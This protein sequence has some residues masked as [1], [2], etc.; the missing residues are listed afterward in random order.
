MKLFFF[1]T[2]FLIQI[3][4]L[5]QEWQWAY[6]INGSSINNSIDVEIDTAGNIWHI[7]RFHSTIDADPGPFTHYLTSIDPDSYI[8]KLDTNMN[9]IWS[10]NITGIDNDLYTD[11]YVHDNGDMFLTGSFRNN[12]DLDPGPGSLIFNSLDE[13]DGFLVKMDLSGNVV[14]AKIIEGYGEQRA[15]SLT[16]NSVG[17][18][19]LLGLFAD[20]ADFDPGPGIF[21]MNSTNAGT[22]DIFLEKLDASGNF[23]WAKSFGGTWSAGATQVIVDNNDNIIITGSVS[24]QTDL[25]P[26][27]GI[28]FYSSADAND[29][30]VSKFDSAGN[31]LWGH[32]TGGSSVDYGEGIAI[33]SENNI[34]CAVRYQ[35]QFDAK[36]GP[37]SLMIIN[38]GSMDGLILKLNENG[39]FIWVYEIAGSG[40][41]SCEKIIIDG[42][43]QIFV[44]GEYGD[45]VDFDPTLVENW[46]S[47][48]LGFQD[49]FVLK[50][51]TS[52]NLCWVNTYGS[53]SQDYSWGFDVTNDGFIA[54][55]GHLSASCDF[56]TG[57]G[58]YILTNS[59]VYQNSFLTT[60]RDLNYCNINNGITF[61]NNTLTAEET[62]ATYQWINCT[63]E[64]L[65][66]GETSK[67][68]VVT[69]PGI[70][71]AIIYKGCCIDTTACVS[72]CPTSSGIDYQ[73]ACKTYSWLDG[74]TYTSSNNTAIFNLVGGAMNGC[75]SIIYL[76]LTINNVSDLNTS[77][78]GMSIT[79]NNNFATSF[80]W[81]DCDN[82]FAQIIGEQNQTFIATS[83]GNYAVEITENECIDTSACVSLQ[84]TG[85]IQNEFGQQFQVYPNPTR[86]TFS[87]ELGDFPSKYDAIVTD[88][89]GNIIL[90]KVIK[91]SKTE[92]VDLNVSPGEYILIIKSKE[93]QAIVR[94]LVTG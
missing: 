94:L 27:A 85:I 71:A 81:L 49:N 55:C 46:S 89:N 7:G 4:V 39:N 19:I 64:S 84:F 57:P 40:W 90:T 73:T 35:H 10:G 26:G 3:S 80:Q 86:G 62:G 45:S 38:Q 93:K 72:V 74:N 87:I 48:A 70:Y 59:G 92:T 25:D 58:N 44:A 12:V 15:T 9:Y 42:N 83:S 41:D 16:V 69:A 63:D 78:N 22:L 77:I 91:G 43:D 11:I 29:F 79:A 82:N 28:D 21:Q 53:I 33:D 2:T 36:P 24:G 67:N 50:M 5:C 17:E 68:Y 61:S 65:I 23:I 20:S 60:F 14:W 88:L 34:Y 18:I 75:D 8:I 6:L 13:E 1:L 30:F 32:A 66:V 47:A 56:D 76:N 31:Y 37:D 54:A 52:K 51:D